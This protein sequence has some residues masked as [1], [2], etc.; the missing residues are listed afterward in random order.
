[1]FVSS[2]DMNRNFGSYKDLLEH[3]QKLN[4]LRGKLIGLKFAGKTVFEKIILMSAG[5]AVRL[6]APYLAENSCFDLTR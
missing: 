1:M 2:R 4:S 3:K 5:W 6:I